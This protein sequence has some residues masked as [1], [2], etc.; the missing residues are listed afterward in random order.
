M[1]S[2]SL[3]DVTP[4]RRCPKK[5]TCIGTTKRLSRKSGTYAYNIG[6]FQLPWTAMTYY[7]EKPKVYFF[8]A[9]LTGYH[10]PLPELVEGSAKKTASRNAGASTSS[11]SPFGQVPLH[12]KGH[13][14]CQLFTAPGNAINSDRVIAR[15]DAVIHL[16]SISGLMTRNDC[17]GPNAWLY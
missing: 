7:E 3:G 9:T 4:G 17:G 12:R 2:C 1:V 11:A 15:P 10:E 14:R 16:R 8:S 5:V 13:N 6:S